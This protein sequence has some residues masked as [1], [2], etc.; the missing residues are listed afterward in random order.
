MCVCPIPNG[1][2]DR[3]ISLNSSLN[4]APNNVLSS[5]RTAPLYGAC[6]SVL[7]RQLTV[8]IG[9]CD[10]VVVLCKMPHIFTNDEYANMLYVYSLCDGSATAAVEEYR[11][12]FPMRRIPDHSVFSKVFNTLLA[13]S[14]VLMFHLNEHVNNMWRNRKAYL[15][16][17]SVALLLARE[18]F[19]H[20]SVFHEH[21]YGEQCMNTACTHFTH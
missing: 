8:V 16:W 3:D 13:C 17:Y 18:D 21:V 20:V 4:L 5:R 10:V 19:L 1:F 2:Q 14:Q 6:D 7:K 12:R 15:K 9:E 11:W